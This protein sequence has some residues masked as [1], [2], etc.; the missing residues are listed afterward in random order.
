[1]QMSNDAE[2]KDANNGLHENPLFTLCGKSLCFHATY[3]KLEAAKKT[4]KDDKRFTEKFIGDDILGRIT[5]NIVM[6]KSMKWDALNFIK[7]Q[8]VSIRRARNRYYSVGVK[9]ESH[10]EYVTVSIFLTFVRSHEATRVAFNENGENCATCICDYAHRVF[11]VVQNGGNF[12]FNSTEGKNEFYG[13]FLEYISKA[14]DG[15]PWK[16]D[17]ELE[18]EFVGAVF[19]RPDYEK[20]SRCGGNGKPMREG[21]ITERIYGGA[22]A[23]PDSPVWTRMRYKNPLITIRN[24]WPT[25]SLLHGERDKEEDLGSGV[26]ENPVEL[27]VCTFIDKRAI[28]I[29]SLGNPQ[30]RELLHDGIGVSVVYSLYVCFEDVW[31]LG[32]LIDNIHQLGTLRV[33]SLKDLKEI[34]RVANELRYGMGESDDN[35]EASPLLN[36]NLN[37]MYRIERSKRYWRQFENRALRLRTKS[38][39]GFQAYNDFVSRRV[40]DT[41]GF[42]QGVGDRLSLWRAHREVESVIK[43]TAELRKLQ[44]NAELLLVIPILY[45]AR[46]LCKGIVYDLLSIENHSF[47]GEILSWGMPIVITWMLYQ[48]IR[49]KQSRRNKRRGE[50][51]AVRSQ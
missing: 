18:A 37:L 35:D 6:P 43:N 23:R 21:D 32:R 50:T 11:D 45:Y 2:Q 9:S 38:V 30:E 34:R 26:I 41:V 4:I 10:T 1:M 36:E 28:Y 40:K 17:V 31:Q 7:K 39:E 42:I 19:W 49:S 51:A 12:S 27:V 8:R 13:N 16:N 29:S 5:N 48:H 14:T 44:E 15:A 22:G 24:I 25:V 47:L 46:G 20:G 3:W 33:A